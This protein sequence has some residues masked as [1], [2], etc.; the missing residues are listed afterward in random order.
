MSSKNKQVY[1]IDEKGRKMYK[2]VDKGKRNEHGLPILEPLL[3]SDLGEEYNW[4]P[5]SA[6]NEVEIIEQV[7]FF[8]TQT[9]LWEQQANNELDLPWQDEF[10]VTDKGTEQ[11]VKEDMGIEEEEEQGINL[12]EEELKV[13]KLEYGENLDGQGGYRAKEIEYINNE[14]TIKHSDISIGGQKVYSN[15]YEAQVMNNHMH[16]RELAEIHEKDKAMAE[17]SR[18]AKTVIDKLIE[19]DNKRKSIGLDGTE[20]I[21]PWYGGILNK[22]QE[23]NQKIKGGGK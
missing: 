9:G 3:V 6:K 19:E 13:K 14:N 17:K 22:L 4:K 16:S 8:N 7:E 1:Y 11:E 20:K 15:V 23:Y 12:S 2:V 21:S 18:G 5:Q 10:P